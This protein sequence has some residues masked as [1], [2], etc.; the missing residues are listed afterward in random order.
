MKSP[1]FIDFIVW[2]GGLAVVLAISIL[3]T[4]KL[5]PGMKVTQSL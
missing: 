5:F 2:V 3:T 1:N 4:T